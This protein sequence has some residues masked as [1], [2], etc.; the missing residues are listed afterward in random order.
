MRPRRS[1]SARLSAAPS[2][3]RSETS[4][5]RG[6]LHG[7][8]EEERRSRRGAPERAD[9][10]APGHGDRRARV[11]EDLLE[12]GERVRGRGVRR[13]RGG[14]RVRRAPSRTRRSRRRV[15][16]RGRAA[17][18]SSARR[19]SAGGPAE[20]GRGRASSG[21]RAG[22]VRVA[23]R[24][25][26]FFPFQECSRAPVARSAPR[27]PRRARRARRTDTVAAAAPVRTHVGEVRGPERRASRD[28]GEASST[29]VFPCPL[30]PTTRFSARVEPEA[31]GG[32]VPEGLDREDSDLHESTRTPSD[33]HRHHDVEV[34]LQDRPAARRAGPGTGTPSSLTKRWTFF[35]SDASR[36][37]SR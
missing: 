1:A 32:E 37:C 35:V 30:S 34:A 11:G 5:R 17:T 25:V 8:A 26:T 6:P 14:R 21:R 19:R 12:G 20:A 18:R 7:A 9:V 31:G 33:A 22:S 15:R 36:N 27:S 3:G 28:E 24:R 4:R 13:R 23:S 2:A 16:A 29:F 10:P